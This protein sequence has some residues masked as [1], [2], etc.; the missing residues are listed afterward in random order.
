MSAK[1]TALRE[2]REA[3]SAGAWRDAV[4]ACKA[5]L[6]DDRAC[7]EAYV[8][9]G[10]AAYHLAE[11]EQ[12]R[13]GPR[14]RTRASGI[15]QRAAAAAPAAAAAA[16]AAE[17][18]YQKATELNDKAAAAWQGLSQLYHDTQQWV[19]AA[20]ADQTLV[21]LALR[22]D[23]G[24]AAKLPGL[25]RRLGEAH[26]AAGQLEEAEVSLREALGRD[27]PR[28]ER[29]DMLAQLADVQLAEDETELEAKVAAK[30]VAA[31]AAA[32]GDGGK[33]C[34]EA[35]RSAV[36]S[37]AADEALE[38]D[39]DHATPTLKEIVC[40]AAPTPP[41]VKYHDAYLRRRA[42]DS[43]GCGA[44]RR[45]ATAGRHG[46]PRRGCG[47]PRRRPAGGADA[48]AR[49]RLRRAVNVAAPG[50]MDRH[51]RRVAV[52]EVCR[53]MMEGRCAAA[54]E[55]AR[56]CASA[57]AYETALR[58]L[59]IEEEIAGASLPR[60]SSQVRGRGRGRG[61]GGG[62]RAARTLTGA[63]RAPPPLQE[64]TAGMRG[65][66]SGIASPRSGL[67]TPTASGLAPSA[68]LLSPGSFFGTSLLGGGRVGSLAD[69]GLRSGLATP[70]GGS[71]AGLQAM[72]GGMPPL[73][74]G[75]P[76]RD[77][78]SARLSELVH[79]PMAGAAAAAE[80]GMA[81]QERESFSQLAAEA[82]CGGSAAVT[83]PAGSAAAT[84]LAG[85]GSL[86]NGSAFA[87][88]APVSPG[89]A[90]SP[91]G[92]TA[93]PPRLNIPRR[94]SGRL[95]GA[96]GLS[97]AVGSA[98]A[99]GGLVSRYSSA[100]MLAAGSP[101]F[102]SSLSGGVAA[103]LTPRTTAGGV[104]PAAAPLLMAD[105]QMVSRRLAHA[106]P[107]NATARVHV[108]MALRRREAYVASAA[109]TVK[110][111][112]D[113]QGPGVSDLSC[114]PL[115]QRLRAERPRQLARRAALINLLDKGLA[116]GAPVVSGMIGLAELRLE[117]GDP[118]G[119]LEA[120]KRGI[121][122]VF[123][124][125]KVGKERARHAALVLN[126]LAAQALLGCGQATDAGRIF[127]RLAARVSEGEVAF[128][129]EALGMPATS[130]RQQAIRGLAQVALAQGDS[131]Q[132]LH[133][134]G[135]L[136][137]KALMGRGSAEHWAYAEYG[138]LLFQARAGAGSAGAARERARPGVCALRAAREGAEGGGQRARRRRAVCRRAQEGNADAGRY[139]LEAAL[140]VLA[141]AAPLPP[142]EAE[143]VAADYHYKLARIYWALGGA[144]RAERE[145]C[146][147]HLLD[148]AAVEGPQQAT[149]F[150]WL[151]HW[152]AQVGDDEA[153]ARKCYQRALALDPTL[154]GAGNALCDLLH[155]RGG[156]GAPA[157]EGGL[158]AEMLARAPDAAWA[159]VR[160]ARLE[161][162]RGRY[163]P[164]VAAHQAAIRSAPK[165]ACL[166]E[167]LGASYQ[168]LGR[169]ASALKAL[170]RAL[171]LDPARPY[172]LM[173]CGALH[174][175]AGAYEDAAAAYRGALALAP[176]HPAALLGLGEVLLASGCRHAAMGAAGA[177][178]LELGEAASRAGE[179]AR[180]A[181]NL[182]TAWKLLGDV[183]LQQ[184]LLQPSAAAAAD[185]PGGG[186][187]GE[188]TV[189]AALV[190]L[191]SR[192]GL[193]RSARRAYAHALALDPASGELWGDVALCYSYEAQ[194][195][196]QLQPPGG[197]PGAPAAAIAAARS[198]A[199]STARGGLRLAPTSAWLWGV[200][201]GA[202][203][204]AGDPAAA[205]YAY[206]RALALDPRAAATWVALGRLYSRHGSAELA[207]QCY[208]AARGSEPTLVSVW[209]AMAATAAANGSAAGTAAAGAAAE[210]AVGLGGGPESWLAY[211]TAGLRSR[212]GQQEG[213][214]LA[215]AAK[216]SAHQ[217]LLLPPHAA[218]AAALEA[219][220]QHGSAAAAL[221]YC[222]ALLRAGQAQGSDGLAALGLSGVGDGFLQATH[223]LLLLPPAAGRGAAPAPA[224]GATAAAV[225]AALRLALARNL[226]LSGDSAGALALYGELEADGALGGDA[227]SPDTPSWLA[228]GHAALAAGQPG[229]CGRVLQR[230]VEEAADERA[231]LAAVM[232]LL[233]F[234]IAQGSLEA[235]FALLL[236]HLPSLASET[237]A[238]AGP[239]AKAWLALVVAAAAARAPEVLAQVTEVFRQ[240]VAGQA[241]HLDA[242]W[243][244][245]ELL[246]VTAASEAAGGAASAAVRALARGVH[247]C[248]WHVPARL[249]LAQAVLAG[250]PRA[251]TA[252]YRACPVLR[253]E[254]Y[255][256]SASG[257]SLGLAPAAP[258]A[259][260]AQHARP[261]AAP[262]GDA[263][264]LA[265]GEVL[266][267][268]SA[269]ATALSGQVAAAVAAQA[270]AEVAA[271]Q[272]LL[273]GLPSS[274]DVWYCLALSAL[275]RA[276]GDGQAHHFRA[277]R[278]AC[279]AALSRVDALIATA[280]ER[281]DAGGAAPG[282]P[283]S[284]LHCSRAQ[285]QEVRV[286]LMVAVSECA[287]HSRLPG[288]HD[289]ART[290]AMDALSAALG[291]GG[292]GTATAH[293]QVG[294]MLAL[295][296]MAAQAEM[297]Y[298]QAVTASGG[299]AAGAVL[300]L[301]KLLA[302]Q[303]RQ[304]EAVE[305]LHGIWGAA[306]GGL[307]GDG[308][309]AAP[310]AG[311]GGG[312][313]A[314]GPGSTFVE[315]AAL[316]EALL[317]AELGQWD[318]ARAAAAEGLR[319]ARASGD[320]A[321]AAAE[322][323]TASVALAAAIAAA[324]PGADA[325]AARP[326]LLEARWAASGAAKSG[327]ALPGNVG[328][329]AA[330]IGAAVLAAV[331]LARGKLQ[332]AYEA[333]GMSFGAWVDQAVPAAVL[334]A[335]GG[336]TG[337]VSDCAAALTAA[338]ASAAAAGGA[339]PSS[340]GELT[341]R[342]VG[343]SSLPFTFIV[344]PQVLQ[345]LANIQAGQLAAL[346]AI[347]WVGW[348]AGL[349]GNGLMAVYLAAR[350]ERTAVNVQL[351]GIASNLAVLAQLWHAQVMPTQAF[352]AVLVAAGAVAAASAARAAGRLGDA[353]W[354]PFEALAG[355]VGVG[356][357]PQVLWSAFVPGPASP[358]PSLVAAAAAAL[359]L[360]QRQL[361]SQQAL[362]KA[363]SQLP[364]LCATAMFALSPIPQ[365]VRNFSDLSSLAGLSLGTMLL[366]LLGNAVCIPRALF[367]RDPA[368]TFGATWGCL[369]M[370]WAQLLSL[371]LGTNP[372]TGARFLPVPAFL[373]LS[374]SLFGYLSWVVTTDAREKG[375]P[376][377]ASYAD[378]YWPQRRAA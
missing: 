211:A 116:A 91:D 122:F 124:R 274:P 117:A 214:L 167:A 213:L 138:W 302:G 106:F 61:R 172:A 365:L 304:A 1:R 305:L 319:L 176:G 7:Y 245:C 329:S 307:A 322:L 5:A 285:L 86:A 156:G 100:E 25:V 201:A 107:W 22:G 244:E 265:L 63:A 179:A 235:G 157:L 152:Y 134:Y 78:S 366:A 350:G 80:A 140:D 169:H 373:A 278:R 81:E 36:L 21:D 284:L 226:A 367:T 101:R 119:A 230:A 330:G 290:W 168:A 300:E 271:L 233:Q 70:R 334:V 51:N 175:M 43:C 185:A 132:A 219:R 71:T 375:L 141:R 147:T 205:E 315:A 275:L 363:I 139:Q 326:L 19:K 11:F 9:L 155:A 144:W 358:A 3:L 37:E 115:A 137:S 220:G 249:R 177:A 126:L 352:A 208:E 23:A 56:G 258:P 289:D 4:T 67:A 99:G 209:E 303:G 306:A 181:N 186:G 243:V 231:R 310:A 294:R 118:Q 216:A 277:A 212:D 142:A 316:E 255:A 234:H 90:A 58:L 184:H 135:E 232:A 349:A 293:R 149:A 351:I 193:L 240:V 41:Y 251:A 331:E 129:S 376:P 12:A 239:C 49:R 256:S 377:L 123:E 8:Y 311:G 199:V 102:A 224:G 355:A 85:A 145:H 221:R 88:A 328:I 57:Y 359:W 180:G 321:P 89:A 348:C 268:A 96:G 323:V 39:C 128:G 65:S 97:L 206:S 54:P 276:V 248:P 112:C 79:N 98:T 361:G 108:A 336:L 312:G 64:F 222:L 87:A 55:R 200:L 353:Q 266:A 82:S 207:E 171:E 42:H 125:N 291:A 332:K 287:Q 371:A 52:L 190:H 345:N 288:C 34:E 113:W 369:L 225:E 18:S 31:L 151:G 257:A 270:G 360:K 84:P 159:R 10:K 68:S 154:E 162:E 158:L 217:P 364:G 372:A 327:M 333:I 94:S 246:C 150:E 27:M 35:V 296:G 44:P 356:A 17:A 286:R 374:A 166:W 75:T 2:A 295:E 204:A 48:A 318:A 83:P 103:L 76:R 237:T 182:V 247:T 253:P 370:G 210:H 73:G 325:D 120:A 308:A 362:R 260:Q 195:L 6:K 263:A 337:E 173:A 335:A 30:L 127:V 72:A 170:T 194:L 178:A 93:A 218:L 320:T 317:L 47:R 46:A 254:A 77:M 301:A 38:L 153:R 14:R 136:V 95:A 378:V 279:L 292:V 187:G 250:N 197:A 314:L 344:V 74:P 242:A 160:L 104:L 69:G 259:G 146:H 20:D 189:A 346:A 236:Q 298:R 347:S 105:L 297:A 161:L 109:A 32:G 272:R 15:A 215:C 26:V 13:R 313:D 121:Q 281:P 299:A 368:W 183:Q 339:A 340:Y 114:S 357:A 196:Q 66:L 203:A 223:R 227:A 59:E 192:R 164:A 45:G 267:A 188:P 202:L 191:A 264:A 163:E 24:L 354:L 165:D 282:G 343:L 33:V 53:A 28:H 262:G 273:H 110:L 261:A 131:C 280:G 309:S 130:I 29:L 40:F 238:L 252:A 229:L 16:A 342:L 50:S 111:S 338:R 133:H 198:A 148:A 341:Q 143:A 174:Y 228:Y 269:R 324:P 92:P 60:V 241:P 283:A 62:R